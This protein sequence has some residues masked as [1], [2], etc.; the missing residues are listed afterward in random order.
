MS[1]TIARRGRQHDVIWASTETEFVPYGIAP[2]VVRAR[3]LS[4]TSDPRLVEH[5]AVRRARNHDGT[6]ERPA[7][8]RAGDQ[9][10]GAAR[11]LKRSGERDPEEADEPAMTLCAKRH[12]RIARTFIPTAC[13]GRGVAQDAVRP[14]ATVVRGCRD[15]DRDRSPFGGSAYLIRRNNRSTVRNDVRLDLAP[16]LVTRVMERIL[17]DDLEVG[18]RPSR[19]GVRE[20]HREANG[21]EGDQ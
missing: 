21:Q 14:R 11:D 17:A 1:A 7:V 13:R 19:R 18:G 2:A 15:T 16:M 6:S 3:G 20:L 8:L 4:V 10:G 5:D 12:A 9:D